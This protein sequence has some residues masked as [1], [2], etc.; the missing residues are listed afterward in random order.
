MCVRI[1]CLFTF[2]FLICI[3]GFSQDKPAKSNQLL[4]FPVITKSIET[5]WS[6]GTVGA[7]VFRPSARDTISRTSNLEILG[8]YSTKKQLVTAINGSQYFLH[9]RYIFK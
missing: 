6:F 3:D 1:T 5:G 2:I 7:L 4:I 8:L 9:E